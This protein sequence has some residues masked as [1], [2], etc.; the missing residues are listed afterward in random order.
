MSTI[1]EV[2]ELAG[3]SVAT[4]SRALSGYPHISAVTRQ[5]VLDAVKQ[6]DYQPDQV[7]RSLRRRR[8]NLIG[9]VVSTIENV[10]FTEV[11]H[12]AE[13]AARPLGYNLIVCNTDEDPQNEAAYLTILNRQLVAGVI[14][15]PAPGEARHLERFVGEKLPIVLVNRRL[16]H[17]PFPSITCDDEAAAFE[18]VNYLIHEGKRRIAAIM[19]LPGVSTTGER[20]AGYRRALRAA[21]LSWSAELEAQGGAN[22]EGGYRAAYELMQRAERP[23][24][25]FVFNN[26][27]TQG[28][29]MA[30]QDLG[31]TWPEPVDVAG[32][33]AFA[34]ARLYR[35]PLTVIAQPAHEIGRR[36][37]TMLLERVEGKV[38][39]D[40]ETVVLPN[41]VITR[42]EWERSLFPR[43]MG[44]RGI[45]DRHSH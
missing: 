21:G 34:A 8:T 31:I 43:P 14:L 29:V 7:A 17:L 18:C 25:L 5:R 45:E 41:R 39:D 19:G 37:V 24:A 30:L 32:F 28:A 10:F 27:M 11:A 23:D 4:A 35:P 16:A 22:L 3:V 6:L 15:A 33:G 1:K 13:Q 44:T 42:E 20:L 2:A 26:V 40:G 36:A 12:A 38:A 9:L